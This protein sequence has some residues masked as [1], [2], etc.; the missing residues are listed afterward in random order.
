M[1]RPRPG[2]GRGVWRA[3]TAPEL[4]A[5]KVVDPAM[6]SGAF[7]VS[8]CRY[9]ADRVVDAWDRDGVPDD[10]AEL[11]DAVGDRDE[12]LLVARRRVVAR[13]LYGVDRDDMAVELA[14]LSLWL[15][16][17]AKNKPFG[18]LDHA[19]RCGDSLVGLVSEHQVAAFHLDPAN[20]W[21]V[22]TDLFRTLNERIDGVLTDVTDIREQIESTVVQDA[23]DA[24]EKA[25][26]LANA[27]W[28]TRK[29]RLAADAVVGAALSTA[30]RQ[31]R[32][33]ENGMV[34]DNDDE[35]DL[36]DRLR[37]I[38]DDVD[39]LTRD[40]ADPSLEDRLRA[41]IEGWLRGGRPEPIRPLHWPLEFPEVMR[42][43]GFEAVVG[44]PP[45]IGGKRVSGAVG[46]DVREYL[47]TYIAR[48]K[49]GNADLCS[50]FLLRDLDISWRGRV[51]IIA[52][53]T[54]AQGDTREVGLDQAIGNGVSVYRAVKSQPW[55][56]TASLQV[57]LVWIGHAQDG[58]SRTL[59]GREV[60]AITPSLDARSR[61]SGNPHRLAANANQSFQGCVVLGMGFV[62]ESARA[63]E[64]I[65]ADPRNK[66]VLFPFLNGEDLNSRPDCSASRWVIDF[67]ERSIEEAADYGDCFPIVE[68]EVKS[69]R[70][71]SNR[72]VY[73]ERWWR[74]AERQPA[75]RRAKSDLDRVLVIALVSKTGLPVWV[76]ARQ[77]QSHALGVFVLD[78]DAYLT[79]LSSNLHFAWWTTKG[80]STL[81]TRLR[82][83]PSDGF[84][85]FPLPELT[86][87]MDRVG[88]EL[89][90][91]RRSV[92]LG[93]SLGL[94][95]LYNLVH[96]PAVTD[97][98]IRRLREIHTE[99][100]YATAQAYGWDDLDLGHGFHDTRQGRRFTIAPDVQVEVLDRLLELNHA[101]Y[102]DEVGQ[103]R[104]AKKPRAKRPGNVAHRLPLGGPVQPEEPLF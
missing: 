104:H 12:L 72:K 32:R 65:Q 61:V 5:L 103:G 96:D 86:A 50:Y 14:K 52:T 41:T 75:L 22:G 99:I 76:S 57:S 85:T 26:L 24:A 42:R 34:V 83:T 70:Q 44:N 51:G 30:V 80:E 16:T 37:A 100:D 49:P 94:T 35:E 56:G 23:R 48:D 81:E 10:D 19:L 45:F 15:V 71:L 84:E 102:A 54:I 33:Y 98:E 55:P 59:D 31:A 74:F 64:L 47:K 93:R 69:V 95:K 11:L 25:E 39:L 6:G 2:A 27:E 87:R 7:L 101:R 62:L 82:Y 4:L 46:K 3:K 67:N 78:R 28:M 92:M 88:E 20:G 13:C 9:L 43:G 68:N 53:N 91:V 29:L 8:A 66:D 73:R 40:L 36:D 17:L 79:L 63:Q 89:H 1:L 18:F 58:E 38:A 21:A 90:S 97:E 60:R 77:V